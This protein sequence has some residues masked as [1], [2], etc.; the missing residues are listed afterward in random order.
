MNKFI[1]LKPKENNNN[2]LIRTQ[3][4]SPTK[5]FEA[6][7]VV[8]ALETSVAQFIATRFKETGARCVN[9][10]ILAPQLGIVD[11]IK[12]RVERNAKVVERTLN[13]LNVRRSIFNSAMLATNF[14]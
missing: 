14:R 12:D 2:Y 13:N 1:V 3:T 7:F 6:T 8:A 4:S 5:L 11:R 9:H 10:K